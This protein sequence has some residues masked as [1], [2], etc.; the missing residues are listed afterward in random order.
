MASAVVS[1]DADSDKKAKD[2]AI[3]I[4]ILLGVVILAVGVGYVMYRRRQ[5]KPIF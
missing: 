2:I 3:V 5:N 1:R 4:S